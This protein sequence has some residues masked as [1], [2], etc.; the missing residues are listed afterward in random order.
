MIARYQYIY[1]ATFVEEVLRCTLPL[2]GRT[3]ERDLIKGAYRQAADRI[4]NS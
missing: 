4:V 2:G 3:V 1:S